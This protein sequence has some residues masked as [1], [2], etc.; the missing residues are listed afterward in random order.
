[1]GGADSSLITHSLQP[2]RF[3]WPFK[4]CLAVFCLSNSS[5]FFQRSSV[6]LSGGLQ[7]VC[8]VAFCLQSISTQNSTVDLVWVYA[9]LGV[10][11]FLFFAQPAY[12]CES[13]SWLEVGHC[14]VTFVQNHGGQACCIRPVSAH[15]HDSLQTMKRSWGEQMQTDV[16]MCWACCF[17]P[18]MPSEPQTQRQ[19]CLN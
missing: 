15:I 19:V 17:I 1:M 16:R 14:S 12:T 7:F 10:L 8:P 18:Q 11:F 4:G 5:L 2:H 3:V 9:D 13:C 6:C